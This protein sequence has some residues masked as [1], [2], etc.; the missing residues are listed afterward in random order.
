MDYSRITPRI[1]A[2]VH[3]AV[4]KEPLVD[5][6][7]TATHAGQVEV[8]SKR[9]YLITQFF[10]VGARGFEPP[11]SRSRTVR[12]IRA[13]PR[14]GKA[15]NNKITFPL[16]VVTSIDLVQVLGPLIYLSMQTRPRSSEDR[17]AVS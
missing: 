2:L 14:P 10:L 17:A 15:N 7:L 6:N 1:A 9:L 12:A 13:A 3:R 5:S 8:A 16:P 4:P 11:T